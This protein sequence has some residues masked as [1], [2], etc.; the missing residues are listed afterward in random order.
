MDLRGVEPRTRQCEC[1][2]IPLYYRPS[3]NEKRRIHRGQFFVYLILTILYFCAPLGV[4]K[5]KV[6]LFFLPM[7][8]E[9]SGERCEI[10]CS[11][12]LASAE[13]TIS[14]VCSSFS[15][16]F[17]IITVE[18]SETALPLVC[19]M[20]R[21]WLI[22]SSITRIRSSEAACRF[23][24]SSYSAFSDRSPRER[25]YSSCSAISRRRVVFMCSS[26]CVSS[27]NFSLLK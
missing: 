23:L 12:I 16:C 27:S 14:Y 26:S 10:L 7:S 11:C 3:L 20:M 15:P 4:S 1:R 19:S 18:P 25:A 22:C 5:E 2:L 8:A 9:P 24:A 13:P 6:S 21:A 17:W